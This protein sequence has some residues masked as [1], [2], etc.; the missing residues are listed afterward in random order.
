[1]W[2]MELGDDTYYLVK[3]LGSISLH[4]P[5]SYALEFNDVLSVPSLKKKL[6]YFFCMAMLQE[7]NL[8]DS[9][10]PLVIVVLHVMW[11]AWCMNDSQFLYDGYT[12]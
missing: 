1:M 5:S 2:I 11:G 12:H 6:L 10:A 8:K 4:I 7:W 9:V 3:C